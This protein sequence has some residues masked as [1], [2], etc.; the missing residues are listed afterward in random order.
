MPRSVY[1]GWA[2]FWP[3]LY[4]RPTLLILIYALLHKSKYKCQ[5]NS[6]RF[7]QVRLIDRIIVEQKKTKVKRTS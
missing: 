5:K 4:S 6:L 1:T 3:T 7:C 2:V